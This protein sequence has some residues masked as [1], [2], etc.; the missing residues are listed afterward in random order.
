[1]APSVEANDLPQAEKRSAEQRQK[2]GPGYR[3]RGDQNVNHKIEQRTLKG[4][5]FDPGKQ[6]P[7]VDF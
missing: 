7:L 2:R 5:L 4:S 3:Q 1:M 6:H